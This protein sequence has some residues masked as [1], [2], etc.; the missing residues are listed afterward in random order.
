MRVKTRIVQKVFVFL[1]LTV[2]ILYIALWLHQRIR[3]PF[4]TTARDQTVQQQIDSCEAAKRECRS[5][6]RVNNDRYWLC[7]TD[8]N[9]D[10]QTRAMNI[11]NMCGDSSEIVRTAD[12]SLGP[13]LLKSNETTCY[14]VLNTTSGSN[15][16]VC[17]QRPPV[18]VTNLMTGDNEDMLP[19]YDQVPYELANELPAVCGAYG[20]LVGTVIRTFSTT[21]GDYTKVSDIITKMSNAYISM[22][23]LS[24][25]RCDSTKTRSPELL[26]SCGHLGTFL[27]NYRFSTANSNV[28]RILRIQTAYSNAMSNLTSTFKNEIEPQFSGFGCA[29]PSIQKPAEFN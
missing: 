15:Y 21:K 12:P 24:T 20:S 6:F 28:D 5:E 16:Y 27:S 7:E 13:P 8:L 19:E 26:S 3:E 14:S 1:L 17:Y 18:Q 2:G 25:T 29:F 9:G 22:S 4:Q 11:L 23:N 10:S